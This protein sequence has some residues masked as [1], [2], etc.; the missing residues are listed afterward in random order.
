MTE[1][2]WKEETLT[3]IHAER[4]FARFLVDPEYGQVR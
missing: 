4:R 2:P 1:Q 3:G